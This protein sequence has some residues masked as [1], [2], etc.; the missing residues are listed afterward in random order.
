MSALHLVRLRLRM[1]EFV[2][3]AKD[4]GLLHVT[5][6]GLGYAMHAWLAA[7][8]GASSPKPFRFDGRRGELLGY[9]ATSADAMV[10]HAQA[11]ASPIAYAALCPESLVSKPM[12]TE[13]PV[14]RSLRLDVEVCPVSRKDGDEKDV[15][16]RA[17]DRLG[18]GAPVREVVYR[19]WLTKQL[20]LAVAVQS[21]DI[22]SLTQRERLV[23]P[24]RAATGRRLRVVERPRVQ[25]L[26]Q[27]KVR[28]SAVFAELLARGVG[29]HRAFGFG[30]LL[31]APGS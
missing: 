21:V 12:P 31:L 24:D 9:A 26:V 27:A 23:R 1:P 28:D 30:M 3:F 19:E 7:M 17:L 16:L 10:A 25:C 29:R 11:F 15:Y 14:G 13:W 18:D 20:D 4:Q 5:E 8:F 6:E 2:R 22:A